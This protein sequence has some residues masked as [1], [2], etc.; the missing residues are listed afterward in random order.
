MLYI[1]V[2]ILVAFIPL[3][4]KKGRKYPSIGIFL[5]FIVEIVPLSGIGRKR[6]NRIQ[7]TT[8]NSLS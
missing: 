6:N 5:N 3:A 2:L 7:T 1:T 8:K 4:L